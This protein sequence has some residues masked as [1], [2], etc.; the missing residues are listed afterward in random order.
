MVRLW[1]TW[2]SIDSTHGQIEDVGIAL[3]SDENV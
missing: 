2:V 1:K 3:E